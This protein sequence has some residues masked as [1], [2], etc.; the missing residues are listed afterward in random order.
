MTN[1]A[2]GRLAAERLGSYAE[3]PKTEMLAIP[4]ERIAAECVCCGSA[5]LVSAPAILMPFVADRAFGWKPVTIDE[6]WGLRTIPHGHAFSICR[7]LRCLDCEHLFC[8]I[9][10]SD[11]ELVALYNKY[12]EAEY[13]ALREHYEPGYSARNERLQQPIG[14]TAEIE[15]FLE[16]H[17]HFPLTVLDWGGDTGI[18]TPFKGKNIAFDIYDISDKEVEPGAR[19]VTLE[20]ASAFKYRLIVCSQLLEH[21]PYPHEILLSA[22][23]AMDGRS[24]L[25]IELPFED[26]M[27]RKL[28]RP[29]LE[30][31]HWHEH[32]NFYSEQSLAELIG[33]CGFEIIDWNVLATKVAGGDV[34]V[35]Q[36]ACR[37][38]GDVRFE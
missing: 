1:P 34:H 16:P 19:I 23:E 11:S 6:S 12:R 24:V 27:R 36:V 20:Q 28:D 37:L 38:G 13:T 17:L 10:F 15:S 33:N 5:N 26:V 25:Y 4:R 18:N 14:Y 2:G 7:T 31:R 21:V 9:R 8:D 22:R 35:F 30:K 32:I 3:P 29:E